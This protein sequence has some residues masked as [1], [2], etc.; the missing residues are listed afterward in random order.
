M[1]SWLEALD[2]HGGSPGAETPGAETLR[3]SGGK[4]DESRGSNHTGTLT[5]IHKYTEYLRVAK[6]AGLKLTYDAKINPVES[7]GD[8]NSREMVMKTHVR[9]G[10]KPS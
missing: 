1:E 2:L 5:F 8:E 6:N 7:D 10:A 3:R 4:R 9:C